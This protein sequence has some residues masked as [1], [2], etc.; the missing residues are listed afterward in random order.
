L[1]AKENAMV[2][3][4]PKGH[5][6]AQIVSDPTVMSG[7]PVVRGTRIPAETIVAELRGGADSFDIF[8]SY[9]SLPVDGIDAVIA[10]AEAKYGP[11]W[12]AMPPSSKPVT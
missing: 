4:K 6:P 10:W 5:I 8:A 12:K 11:D 3:V 2:A 1:K 9:P 7:E